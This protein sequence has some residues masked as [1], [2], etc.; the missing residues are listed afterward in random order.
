MNPPPPPSFLPP[1]A[2]LFPL[3]NLVWSFSG[4]SLMWTRPFFRFPALELEGSPKTLTLHPLF[5]R[6]CILEG[7]LY[8]QFHDPFFLSVTFLF[9]CAWLSNRAETTRRL[10]C[11]FHVDS[12]LIHRTRYPGAFSA[13]F[14]Y[15]PVS[16]VYLANAEL[17]Y[18]LF[19]LLFYLPGHT[20]AKSSRFPPFAPVFFVT[21]QCGWHRFTTTPVKCA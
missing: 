18:S 12:S 6:A 11:L 21:V 16:D 19:S 3:I 14:L 15:R 8:S 5:F 13:T 9:V 1:A 7:H 10:I 17:C 20:H 2:N 4:G